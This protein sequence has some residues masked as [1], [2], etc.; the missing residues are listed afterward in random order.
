MPAYKGHIIGG[1]IVGVGGIVVADVF[2][3]FKASPTISLGL[4][5]ITI[6]GAIF[7]D[8]DTHSKGRPWVYGA[9][10]LAALCLCYNEL[11]KEAAMLGM[12]TMLPCLG[13]HRGW[14]HD[15]WAMI[16]VPLPLVLAPM[17]FLGWD[18]QSTMPYY[19]AAVAGYA[20]H[21]VLDKAL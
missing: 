10:L 19:V 11:F 15:W 2:H 8:I 18:W 9:F 12:M 5:A 17:Y 1:T 4:L 14:T 3:L 21:L 16:V 20:S 13:S 7:P 6:T